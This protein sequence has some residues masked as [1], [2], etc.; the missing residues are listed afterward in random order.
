M[1]ESLLPD[2][3]R[4]QVCDVGAFT[5]PTLHAKLHT[6]LQGLTRGAICHGGSRSL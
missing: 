5:E 4:L 3:M 1:H 6:A 2:S